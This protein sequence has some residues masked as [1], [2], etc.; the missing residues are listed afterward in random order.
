MQTHDPQTGK[1]HD[2]EWLLWQIHDRFKL[3]E[4]LAFAVIDAKG[5]SSEPMMRP[6]V[7][8][9]IYQFGLDFSQYRKAVEEWYERERQERAAAVLQ[10]RR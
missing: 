5:F 4:A 9:G 8:E 7:A 3:I 10:G 6:D 1:P 2:P